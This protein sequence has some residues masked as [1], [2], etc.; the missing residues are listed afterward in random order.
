M[1]NLDRKL[2]D[3]FQGKIVRKDLTAMMKRGI[4][5]PTFVLEYLLGMYC[6]TDDETAIET[7]V[8]KIKKILCENYVRPDESE[9]IKSR[10]RECGEYT[11]IDKIEV[12][13]DE[14]EDLYVARFTNLKIK[15]FE[16][17]TDLVVENTKL[18]TGG[19]WCILRIGYI[20]LSERASEFGGDEG[21]FEVSPKKKSKFASPFNIISLKP[22]QMPNLDI[23]EMLEARKLFTKDEWIAV[24]LRS[25]GYEPTKLSE[26]ERMHYLLRLV[27]LIQKN[28]NLV[29]LGPRGTGKSHVYQEL[30]P[31]SILMSGGHT[32]VSN[33][34]YNMSTRRVGLVGHWDCIAF[35]EVA[36]IDFKDLDGIQILKNYMANGSFARGQSTINS[37]ASICFEGN[38]N[39]TVENMLKTT[40]L[41]APF[42]DGFNSDSA[43]F[44]RIHYY[45]PGWETPK[46]KSELLTE[47]YGLISDC[48]SEFCREM[49]K[50]DF[51]DIFD[52]EYELNDDFNKRD[53]IA[54]R[55]TV[56]GLAKLIYPDR[57]VSK[58][59]LRELLE[60]AIEGRRRVKEQLKKMSGTE[61]SATALGY[62]DRQS[63]EE[64]VVQVPEQ[65]SDSLVPLDRPA[66]GHVYTVGRSV[67]S[68]DVCVYRLENKIVSGTEKFEH[69]NVYAKV[70]AEDL[71]AAFSYFIENAGKV[72][73]AYHISDYDY[74]LY[75]ADLQEKGISYEASM[76]EFIGLCSALSGKPV[77]G[78]MVIVG[79]IKLS[80]TMEDVIGIEDI[81]R[82]SINAGANRI[83]LPTTA[84]SELSGISSTLLT[85]ISPVFYVN[86]I[87]AA[88]IALG[89]TER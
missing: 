14:R 6:S 68:N 79:T 78:S 29:E 3:S 25:E 16:I 76:A 89:L 59:E 26:K 84:M 75:Y 64:V 81:V 87:E 20:P 43:F 38:T 63:G 71:K 67:V 46:L 73:N 21:D 83:L 4:N 70:V 15:P 62:V 8:A 57:N 37:D 45:L 24:I 42:P 85:K 39:D 19:V 47:N 31:Y 11:V 28:Y 52:A 49:R 7:G 36:G 80:G 13:L 41:F 77:L 58:E 60:Y 18:L 66:V 44:D 27:P 22:I 51:T 50:F 5:V 1:D 69:Q 23:S 2:I 33:L 17:S 74:Y 35:D 34:F 32:T 55:K 61:F 56:A 88:R 82:V 53:E 48:L 9:K 86:P 10:I 54:V 72:V 40:N 30:S 65:K 12:S